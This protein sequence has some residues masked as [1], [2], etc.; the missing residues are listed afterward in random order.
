MALVLGVSTG[1]KIYLNDVAVVV[2]K[3]EDYGE[4]M[5]TVGDREFRVTPYE[6]TEI[7]PNVRVS[8]GI[9][10]QPKLEPQP[11][12]IFDAG[13]D[14]VILRSELYERRA[15]GRRP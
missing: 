11:R 2:T 15:N 1:S 12:L 6:S 14:V 10:K 5:L 7:W 8:S 4:I 13:R 9:P 3:A